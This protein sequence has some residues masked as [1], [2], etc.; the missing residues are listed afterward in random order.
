MGLPHLAVVKVMIFRPLMG[1]VFF[2][3]RADVKP[4]NN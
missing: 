4:Q 1:A 2:G 3:Q